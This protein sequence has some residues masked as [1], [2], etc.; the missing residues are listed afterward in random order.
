MF[1]IIE[2]IEYLKMRL[3]MYIKSLF[4][5]DRGSKNT[6]YF[7]NDYYSG[8]IYKITIIDG[9]DMSTS[10]NKKIKQLIAH[11]SNYDIVLEKYIRNDKNEND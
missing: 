8:E 11:L 6:T 2:I 4:E 1:T 10:E 9:D 5:K 3:Y 7:L